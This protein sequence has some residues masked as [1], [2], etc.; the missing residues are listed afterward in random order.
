MKNPSTMER[1][2]NHVGATHATSYMQENL[3][4]IF[5]ESSVVFDVEFPREQIC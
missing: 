5:Q 1:T 2:T 4:S 3:H